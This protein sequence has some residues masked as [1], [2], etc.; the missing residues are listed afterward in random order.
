MQKNK[1]KYMDSLIWNKGKNIIY[2]H[3]TFFTSPFFARI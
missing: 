3:A 2:Q 1:R